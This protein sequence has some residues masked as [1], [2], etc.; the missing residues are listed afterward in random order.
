MAYFRQ[1]NSGVMITNIQEAHVWQLEALQN[2]VYPTLAPEERFRADHY[3]HHLQMFPEGQFC[4]VYDDKV[5]GMCSA[6]RLSF[7][8]DHLDHTF[9]ELLA[10]G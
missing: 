10:G 6:I 1:L 4:A 8:F 9:A 7:D 3:L 5:V 2:I